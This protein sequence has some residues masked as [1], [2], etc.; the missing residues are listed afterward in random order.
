MFELRNKKEIN[1][2]KVIAVADAPYVVAKGKDSNPD[3][4]ISRAAF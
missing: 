2:K 4:S 1:E 3:L